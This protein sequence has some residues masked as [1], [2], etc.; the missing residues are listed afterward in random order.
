M[1]Q[2]NYNLTRA[3][4][5]FMLNKLMLSRIIFAFNVDIMLTILK[6]EPPGY[7]RKMKLVKVY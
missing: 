5:F 3:G 7:I 2:V 1:K 6:H 4:S